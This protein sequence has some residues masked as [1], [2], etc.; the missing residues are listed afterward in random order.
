MH[1]KLAEVFNSRWN[2]IDSNVHGSLQQ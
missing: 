1:A 2:T